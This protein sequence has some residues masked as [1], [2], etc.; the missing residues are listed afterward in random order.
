[1]RNMIVSLFAIFLFLFF[2]AC[3]VFSIKKEETPE[4]TILDA[5]V[6]EKIVQDKG[7]EEVSDEC[8]LIFKKRNPRFKFFNRK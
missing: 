7:E 1:M 3:A 4:K 5:S 6:P 2:F 8:G